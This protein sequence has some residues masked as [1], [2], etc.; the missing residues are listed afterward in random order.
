MKEITTQTLSCE[1]KRELME[2]GRQIRA[3]TI[4]SGLARLFRGWRKSSRRPGEKR[5]RSE[6]TA[7]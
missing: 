4:C 2:R 5:A 1:Q 3:E 7:C 6:T